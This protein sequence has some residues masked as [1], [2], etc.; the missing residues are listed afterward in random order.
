[1]AAKVVQPPSSAFLPQASAAMV[2]M[3]LLVCIRHSLRPRQLARV[4]GYAV[5]R[6]NIGHFSY[7]SDP[8]VPLAISTHDSRLSRNSVA[9]I[10]KDER[11]GAVGK[12]LAW[13]TAHQE[14]IRS[15]I[16]VWLW[17]GSRAV[18]N[19]FKRNAIGEGYGTLQRNLNSRDSERFIDSLSVWSARQRTQRLGQVF[20]R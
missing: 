8:I 4:G 19:G 5:R 13:Q 6:G 9:W 2:L 16:L 14:R 15:L 1:M 11:N 17:L 3:P 20:C 10:G 18:V 7:T 12:D